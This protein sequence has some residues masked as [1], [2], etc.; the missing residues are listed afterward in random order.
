VR[1]IRREDGRLKEIPI[2]IKQMMEAKL[3]DMEVKDQ[4]VLLVPNSTS[5]S[6][7]RKSLES[8]FRSLPGSRFIGDEEN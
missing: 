5:K 7:A 8:R 2:R 1:I 4:D 6:V 3:P